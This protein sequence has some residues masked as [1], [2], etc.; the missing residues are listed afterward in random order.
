M[1]L[2]KYVMRD[3]DRFGTERFY[4]RRFRR[5]VRLRARPGTPEFRDEYA[6][7]GNAVMTPAAPPI[8]K[9]V[10]FITHGPQR[11]K[12][13]TASNVRARLKALQTGLSGR[14]Y[15]FYTTPGD[16]KLEADLHQM[17]ATDR[18]S[19]EWFIF[20]K[21]IRGWIETDERHRLAEGG[22]AR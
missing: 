4:Y 12:I 17:F 19:G 1:R 15:V 13:G 18:L 9:F 7:A 5:K 21:A 10:Y 14:A 11:V 8:P 16:R 22:G 20:S 6:R 2:P 3:T